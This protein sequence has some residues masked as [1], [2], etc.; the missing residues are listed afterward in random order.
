MKSQGFIFLVVT[1]HYFPMRVTRYLHDVLCWKG[2]GGG[3]PSDHAPGVGH[4][5][6]A[7]HLRP[8]ATSCVT[9]TL[10][11][12]NSKGCSRFFK[13]SVLCKT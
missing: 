3:N 2:D 12:G 5:L 4:G 9:E 13:D 11:K 6:P 8:P 1:R 7:G 10:N